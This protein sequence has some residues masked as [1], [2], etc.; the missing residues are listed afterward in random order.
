M[1]MLSGIPWHET[2]KKNKHNR[3]RMTTSYLLGHSA[4]TK[5]WSKMAYE[6]P[7]TDFPLHPEGEGVGPIVEVIDQGLRETRYGAKHKLAIVIESE[8]HFQENGDPLQFWVWATL[9][10]SPKATLTQLRQKLLRRPLTEEERRNFDPERE[11]VGQRVR[12][13]VAHNYSDDGRVYANL[14]SWSLAE[15]GQKV[16][17]VQE[18]LTQ[19]DNG[20]EQEEDAMEPVTSPTKDGNEEGLPF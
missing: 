4:T 19:T 8:T 5:V 10:G 3:Q 7:K 17:E 11:M 6:L 2:P 14:I 13:L 12:Y 16:K 20:Q 9:S 1:E 18:K 15:Q